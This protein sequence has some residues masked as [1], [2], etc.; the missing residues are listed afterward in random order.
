VSGALTQLLLERTGRVPRT[1][2]EPPADEF[3]AVARELGC[4]DFVVLR[5]IAGA[6]G[7]SGAALRSRLVAEL[8]ERPSL[9]GED[10]ERRASAVLPEGLDGGA[11]RG[12]SSTA[13]EPE[14]PSLTARLIAAMDMRERDLASYAR[15][16]EGHRTRHSNGV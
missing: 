12:S 6:D 4:I 15:D 7:L 16:L 2:E 1:Q 13:D 5:A 14:P 3:E 10:F 8:R 11:G 9:V